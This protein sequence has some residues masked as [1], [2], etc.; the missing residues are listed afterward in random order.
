MKINIEYLTGKSAIVSYTDL[1]CNSIALI[2]FSIGARWC[3]ECI[4]NGTEECH[5]LNTSNNLCSIINKSNK[6]PNG[7]RVSQINKYVLIKNSSLFT[8]SLI[9]KFLKYNDKISI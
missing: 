8:N 4:L 5:A 6:L 2:E 9:I 1:G 7:K 3:H